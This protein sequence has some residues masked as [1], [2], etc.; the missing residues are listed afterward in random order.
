MLTYR[1][2]VNDLQAYILYIAY[3]TS[4]ARV[5]KILW[6]VLVALT[7]F[8]VAGSCPWDVRKQAEALVPSAIYWFTFLIAW[9]GLFRRLFVRHSVSALVRAGCNRGTFGIKTVTFSDG[10]LLQSSALSTLR[11]NVDCLEKVVR[12][13]ERVFLFYSSYQ[14]IVIDRKKVSDGCLEEFAQRLEEQISAR[15]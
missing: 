7:L 6:A 8:V 14:A 11:L 15:G 4:A 13:D 10:V 1:Y 2:E 5:E 3:K 12:E 9:W